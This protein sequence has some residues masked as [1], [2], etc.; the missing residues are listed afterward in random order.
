MKRVRQ[1]RK[2]QL[3]N[4]RVRSRMRTFVKK[5]QVL[6]V[7]GDKDAASEAVRTAVSEIDRAAQKGVIHQNNAARRKSRLMHRYNAMA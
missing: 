6:I 3:R 5:A 2:R 7:E 1:N 4:S